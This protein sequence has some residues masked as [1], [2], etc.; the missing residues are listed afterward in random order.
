MTSKVDYRGREASWWYNQ[1]PTGWQGKRRSDCRHSFSGYNTD[2]CPNG[3]L[4][5]K[6]REGAVRQAYRMTRGRIIGS[7]ETSIEKARSK[8]GFDRDV[9]RKWYEW[10]RDQGLGREG[11]WNNPDSYRDSIVPKEDYWLHCG[12]Y[13]KVSDPYRMTR[14]E[15]YWGL[16]VLQ[17]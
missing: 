11:C 6:L 5:L 8:M 2:P 14:R 15:D 3:L 17:R 16:T 13:K 7:I 4:S 10:D 9:L 12:Y 1:I